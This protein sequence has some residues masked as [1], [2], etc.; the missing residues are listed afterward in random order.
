MKKIDQNNNVPIGR[1]KKFLFTV[2]LVLL[3]LF[4]FAVLYFGSIVWRSASYYG[5]HKRWSGSVYRFDKNYGYFPKP[6]ELAYHSLEYGEQVPVI[7]DK[8][9]FRIPYGEEKKHDKS[10]ESQILFLGGSYTHG[11]GV[12]AEKTFAYLTASGLGAAAMNAGGSGWGLSQM[13]IRARDVIPILKP[14]IVVVQYSNWLAERSLTFY[15]PTNLGKPSVPYFYETEGRVN[16]HPPL[17]QS[18]NFKLPVSEFADKDYFS[19]F[20]HVAIPLL[21]YDDYPVAS[22]LIK[23]QLGL[24]MPPIKSRQKAVDFAYKEIQELCDANGANMVILVIPRTINDNPKDRLDA[25][26]SHVVHTLE[27]LIEKLSEPTQEVWSESYRFWRGNPPK[28][29]DTHPNAHM[30]AAIAEILIGAIKQIELKN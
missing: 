25:F 7:F 16:I 12:P 24:L 19:F 26:S 13:V 23:H 6:Y 15:I 28:M 10:S 14:D 4:V 5:K 27:P 30:H 8:N 18:I 3:N 1:R 29:V 2:V 17:F 9:G 20:G 21:V 22:T 11:Y